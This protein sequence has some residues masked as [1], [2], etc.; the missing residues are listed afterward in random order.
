MKSTLIIIVLT[1]IFTAFPYMT[2]NTCSG[3]YEG[4]EYRVAMLSP[5]IVPQAGMRPFFYSFK[6]LN[7]ERPSART[8]RARNSEEWAAFAG[9]GVRAED[10]AD[11]LYHTSP[12]A[13]VLAMKSG[14]MAEAFKGN[15]FIAAVADRPEV[16]RVLEYAKRNEFANFNNPD[17]WGF[18]PSDDGLLMYSKAYTD[19]LEAE[20]KA[21]FAELPEGFL[22]KR[23]AFQLL[24]IYRFK[25][26]FAKALP[27][28]K[29]FEK[30]D[31]VIDPWAWL[32]Q[33]ALYY[34]EEKQLDAFML[35][36]K[37][38]DLSDEKRVAAYNAYTRDPQTQHRL[39]EL[40]KT[41]E[42]KA[43][44]LAFNAT[45]NPGRALDAI[46]EVY[47]LDPA[48]KFLPLL[49]VREVNK[50][51]DWLLGEPMTGFAP[52]YN[53]YQEGR[54][55]SM[56]E[57]F[58][59]R[60]QPDYR[61]KNREKDLAYMRQLRS[62]M[63]GM[64][65]GASHKNADVL[66]LCL[67]HLYIMDGSYA[68]A[69]KM[70]S[71]IAKNADKNVQLQ[72]RIE[73]LI[74][75]AN[76]ADIA[77]ESVKNQL[78][79]QLAYIREHQGLLDNPSKTISSIELY[80]SMLY[81][82]KKDIVLAGLLYYKSR[83]GKSFYDTSVEYASFYE[84]DDE[85]PQG[86][87]WG[88]PPSDSDGESDYLD[89][90]YYTKISFYD[91]YAS[92]ED[93]DILLNVKR[94][95][96]RNKLEKYAMPGKWAAEE[97]Y[98]DLKGTLLFR[99]DRLE[100]AAQTFAKIPDDFWQNAYQFKTYLDEDPFKNT[101][102]DEKTAPKFR[103]SKTQVARRMAELKKETQQKPT[104]ENCYRLGLAYLNTTYNGNS[105]MLFDY[106][107][108]VVEVGPDNY[109]WPSSGLSANYSALQNYREVYYGCSRADALFK[110]A[111]S[112]TKDKDMAAKLQ[113]MLHVC[114]KNKFEALA[115]NAYDEEGN[116]RYDAPL[117]AG[118]NKH[119]SGT[120]TLEAVKECL[121]ASGYIK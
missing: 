71:K 35:L 38:F 100:E 107:K 40:A 58:E 57:S 14:K 92:P 43:S 74:L 48:S 109:Y 18:E 86:Y 44:I 115:K 121:G 67:A 113:F 41:P 26:A 54:P 46:K 47:Q 1:S 61:Q 53:N 85:Q 95:N 117:L 10:A 7:K 49:W 90:D 91:R 64:G 33:A 110:K 28:F 104:A 118:F 102:L 108:S 6:Y 25:R 36:A 112:L 81:K 119:F 89:D 32:H 30:G 34:Q 39:A 63:E 84:W 97:V 80:L 79:D 65:K 77:Q 27:L 96:G 16:L 99:A 56:Y 9:K 55:E 60:Q 120:P 24:R 5:S 116:S 3:G 76:T 13:F 2:A 29:Y 22:K 70:L 75:L 114:D 101:S 66:H 59:E 21:L 68:E 88:A 98:W 72:Q 93:I 51:E 11:I 78:G 23:T 52:V 17:P 83:L 8:D 15:T 106:G 50:L 111:K 69:E 4:E 73:Q 105:W 45:D 62:D 103:F 20:G 94:A 37:A 82:N 31:S 12:D 87:N 42:L 19:K